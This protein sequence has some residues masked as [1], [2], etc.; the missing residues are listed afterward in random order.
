MIDIFSTAPAISAKRASFLLKDSLVWFDTFRSAQ[1][2]KT[3]LDWIRLDQLFE[4]GKDGDGKFIG[5]Y[6]FTTASNDSRKTFNEP[7]TLKDT[8]KF[9]A[10]MFIITLRDALIIE[11]NITDIEDQEWWRD[12]I[13]E[14]N[15]ENMEKLRELY[16]Q[17]VIR[18]AK[19]VLLEGL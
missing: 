5:F 13:L 3:I 17:N 8:G 15:A 7:Y 2:K 10:S 6:S 11:A 1:V 9:Y 14:L 16:K 19:R 12:Q 4:E 18:Y